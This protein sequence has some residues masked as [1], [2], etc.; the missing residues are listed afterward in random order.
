MYEWF[1]AH[2]IILAPAP[3]TDP[4]EVLRLLPF[5]DDLHR[6][7]LLQHTLTFVDNKIS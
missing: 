6:V 1:C 7:G 2:P 5:I 3:N 4:E